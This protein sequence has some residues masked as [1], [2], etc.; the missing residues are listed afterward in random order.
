LHIKLIVS[1][2]TQRSIT[3]QN[4][5]NMAFY[6]KCRFCG[7]NGHSISGCV[8]PNK[9]S[10]LSDMH[11][12]LETFSSRAEIRNYLN[13]LPALHFEVISSGLH[14][15]VGMPRFMMYKT[16]E[17]HYVSQLSIRLSRINRYELEVEDNASM[18]VA[19]HSLFQRMLDGIYH[20]GVST[21]RMVF[22]LRPTRRT[23]EE[24][25]TRTWSISPNLKTV[26]SFEPEECPICLEKKVS[27]VMISPSCP[28]H[29]SYC[30][31][32]FMEYLHK[33]QTNPPACPVCRNVFKHI[34]V[35]NPHL[36]NEYV[37]LFTKV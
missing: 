32:C 37:R 31:G 14:L 16:V 1:K 26:V 12:E 23:A 9:S 30:N 35:Y 6:G 20:A 22:R 24:P 7:E 29:H 17:N 2:E 36:F 21:Y 13:R 10:L 5:T 8:H 19:P 3:N 25:T 33:H 15:P 27:S 34:D 4:R 11:R 18:Y 28:C